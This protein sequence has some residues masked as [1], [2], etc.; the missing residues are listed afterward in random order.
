MS[1]TSND[2]LQQKKAP[3]MHEQF[4]FRNMMYFGATSKR[5]DK[6]EIETIKLG[7]IEMEES[8]IDD[9]GSSPSRGIDGV[10]G[11]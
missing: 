6:N 8:G 3:P 4:E 2:Y 1:S 9:F 7:E 5:S 10:E 11:M